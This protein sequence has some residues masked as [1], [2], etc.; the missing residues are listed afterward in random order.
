MNVN[1]VHR[2]ARS[3]T[4]L[5]SKFSA[6]LVKGPKELLAGGEGTTL[7]DGVVEVHGNE[8]TDADKGR[9]PSRALDTTVHPIKGSIR[10]GGLGDLFCEWSRVECGIC[11]DR[12]E[13]DSRVAPLGPHL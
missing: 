2:G 5:T 3:E 12:R 10:A 8:I 13:A 1:S 11:G 6:K 9:V 4:K 7:S